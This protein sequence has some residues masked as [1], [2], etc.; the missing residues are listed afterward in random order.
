MLYYILLWIPMLLI[1]VANGAL[2][3]AVLMKW[4]N[5]LTAHQIS[6]ATLLL[7]FTLY[8]G[9]I[10]KRFI[11]H[12]SS[13]AIAV[14]VLWL[15][16]TLSFEFGFG[17]WRGNTWEKLFADYNIRQGR[18]WILVPIWVAIAPYFFYQKYC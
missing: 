6:T 17:R 12:S 1:A 3:E 16:L 7:F 4:V 18:V 13:Q 11:P 10:I 8:I 15:V 2:R 14:G 5:N 9:S